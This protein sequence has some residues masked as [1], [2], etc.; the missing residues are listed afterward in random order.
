MPAIWCGSRPR[1]SLTKSMWEVYH[2]SWYEEA[3][4]TQISIRFRP[5]GLVDKFDQWK[6]S[7]DWS[8]TCSKGRQRIAQ[9]RCKANWDRHLI[10]GRDAYQANLHRV[11]EG[12]LKRR[13]QGRFLL[14][15]ESSFW[16][17]ITRLGHRESKH[18]FNLI[19]VGEALCLILSWITIVKHR[20][21]RISSNRRGSHEDNRI[22]H[23]VT[24]GWYQCAHEKFHGCTHSHLGLGKVVTKRCR[25][26]HFED[27]G[28]S[29]WESKRVHQ[30]ELFSWHKLIADAR[31]NA[32]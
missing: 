21:S 20:Q 28:A 3:L 2:R 32:E 17:K 7:V 18:A 23:I 6:L 10:S 24:H 5:C 8:R 27:K 16:S 15:M 30:W 31:L 12:M 13:A 22:P 9:P 19:R 25:H 1:R 26:L 14:C 11:Y 29:E 4:F